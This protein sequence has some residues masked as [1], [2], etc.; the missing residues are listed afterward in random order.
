MSHGLFTGK[1]GGE[2]PTFIVGLWLSSPQFFEWSNPLQKS[3]VNHWGYN[4]LTSRGMSHQVTVCE[5]EAMAID[6]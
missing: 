2:L 3:H 6:L 1:L 5:L 4:L